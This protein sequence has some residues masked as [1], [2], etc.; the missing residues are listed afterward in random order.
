[1]LFSISIQPYN[2]SKSVQKYLE[3]AFALFGV[4][5]SVAEKMER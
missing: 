1:M 3:I 4:D 5:T 2:F